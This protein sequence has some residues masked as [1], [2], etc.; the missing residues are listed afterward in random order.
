M[1]IF[2]II[3]TVIGILLLAI[4]VVAALFLFYPVSYQIQGK[5]GDEVF[6]SGRF[7]WLLH[8]FWFEFA[9]RDFT[10]RARFGVLWFQ[11]SFGEEE[12]D[13]KE[14]RREPELKPKAPVQDGPAIRPKAAALE[15]K[16]GA[17]KM[18]TQRKRAA[19]NKRMRPKARGK[20]GRSAFR[21]ERVKAFKEK[22]VN[23]ARNWK[24]RY[25]HI[26]AEALDEK[27]H[28]AVRHIWA[29]IT[30]IVTHLKPK[31]MRGGFDFS[32][33]DPALTGLLTGAFS[34]LPL[35]YQYEACV[36][37][38]FVSD[39]PYVKGAVTFGGTMSLYHGLL[40][41]IRLIRDKNAM[42]LIQKFR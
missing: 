39:K 34:M 12:E 41:L 13:E 16:T 18:R 17:K 27:N 1:K 25:I 9:V 23:R 31:Y 3:L 4:L 21:L 15:D 30:Y 7:W 40:C 42:Q 29:E 37:P 36:Y 26:K 28:M 6:L 10:P 8:I 11:K 5:A 22:G 19:K 38:D 35:F 2:F 14:E 24:E 33:G 20:P 32:T